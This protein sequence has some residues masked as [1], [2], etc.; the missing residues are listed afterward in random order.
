[1][2]QELQQR[3]QQQHQQPHDWQ[4]LQ[5]PAPPSPVGDDGAQPSKEALQH[6]QLL[7]DMMT[8]AQPAAGPGRRQQ[9]QLQQQQQDCVAPLP[10]QQLKS[11]WPAVIGQQLAAPTRPNTLLLP[12]KQGYSCTQLFFA[13]AA[14]AAASAAAATA[15]ADMCR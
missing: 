14:A 3:R 12:E 10:Q 8:A 1:V 2:R 5:L 15:V 9:Q 13:S 4:W 6:Q 7:A 11:H